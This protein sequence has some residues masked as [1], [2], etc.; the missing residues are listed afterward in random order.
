LIVGRARQTLRQLRRRHAA[1]L[2]RTVQTALASEG[3]QAAIKSADDSMKAVV[4][5]S[6]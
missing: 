2:E 3:K 4:A 6:H 1:E 5:V